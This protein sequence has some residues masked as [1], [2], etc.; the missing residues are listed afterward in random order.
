MS[1]DDCKIIQLERHTSNRLGNL[2]VAS[3]VGVPGFDMKRV[4]FIYDVPGG[5]SRGGHA[6][7]KV[8]EFI[9]AASGAFN[10]TL[11]DGKKSRTITLNRPYIGLLVEPGVWLTLE[12]FSSGAVALVITSDYFSSEDHIKDYDEYLKIVN[13]S[14]HTDPS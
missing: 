14:S 2:S 3:G 5:A 9:V 8:K 4:F 11:N 10:V 7:K 13:H 1:V 12:E 6:H